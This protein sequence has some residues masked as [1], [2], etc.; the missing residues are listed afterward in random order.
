MATGALRKDPES[1]GCSGIA[2]LV[3]EGFDEAPR[4]W[5]G[6][7]GIHRRKPK[8]ETVPILD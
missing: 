8:E 6:D 3:H 4:S 7:P 5:E 1:F 2:T